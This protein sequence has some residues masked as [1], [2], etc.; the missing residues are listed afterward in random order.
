MVLLRCKA[1]AVGLAAFWSS[2]LLGLV[3][4]IRTNNTDLNPKS[5]TDCR[6]QVGECVC[7]FTYWSLNQFLVPLAEWVKFC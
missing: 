2:L 4:L 6:I 3:S 5:I 1:L 7:Q